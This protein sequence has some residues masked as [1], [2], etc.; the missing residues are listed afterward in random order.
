MCSMYLANLADLRDC[1]VSHNHSIRKKV[2]IQPNTLNNLVY[3]SRAVFPPGQK[4]ETHHHSDM[5]EIF[6]VSSGSAHVTVDGHDFVCPAGTCI[7]IEPHEQHRLTNASS[8][9]LVILYLGIP[10]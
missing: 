5:A 6:Y 1:G 10:A 2:L 3:F 9:D 7:A 8:E 4:A